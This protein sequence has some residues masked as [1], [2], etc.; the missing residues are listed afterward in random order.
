MPS[1]LRSA[2]PQ[3]AAVLERLA[4]E[5]R[6]TL[7]V[8]NDRH[9]LREITPYFP[10]LLDGMEDSRSLY[11]VLRGKYVVAPRATS[12]V[13]QAAPFELLV[14]LAL[15][16]QGPYYVAFLSALIAHSLTDLHSEVAYAAIRQD[17]SL[18]VP[19]LKLADRDLRLVRLSPSRWPDG[20]DERERQRVAPRMKEFSWRSTVERTL[21]DGLLRPELCA[22]IETA[23]GAWGR[24]QRAKAADWN[25]VW[26]IAQRCGVSVARRAAYMLCE[27]GFEEIVASDLPR[28]RSNRARVLLD[29]SDGYQL[30]DQR[31]PR[32][33]R[34]GVALNIPAGAVSG[35]LAAGA[36]G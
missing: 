26:Q 21:V 30:A 11:R 15:R 8:A 33:P 12:A 5:R 4:T 36:V 1:A 31:P 34:T 25:K 13:D 3:A 23:V 29:R 20:P 7:I 19:S 17:S 28:L 24:A 6:S 10:Q 14:D 27:L 2:S 22:G 32:D 35:W 9:W 16:D 18:K